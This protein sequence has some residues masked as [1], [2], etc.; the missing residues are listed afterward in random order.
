[1][2]PKRANKISDLILAADK[3]YI[4]LNQITMSSLNTENIGVLA[5]EPGCIPE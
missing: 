3:E 4:D 2:R 5:T 1:M